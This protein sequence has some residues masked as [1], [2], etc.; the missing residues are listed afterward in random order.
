MKLRCCGPR[1][2]ILSAD[3]RDSWSGACLCLRALDRADARA[4]VRKLR[5]YRPR[6]DRRIWWRKSIPLPNEC[7]AA[8]GLTGRKFPLPDAT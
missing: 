4:R 3:A 7:E 1:C 6:C 2:S 5:A 8:G